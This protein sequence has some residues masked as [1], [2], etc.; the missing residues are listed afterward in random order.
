MS[1]TGTT[2]SFEIYE[3]GG[4]TEEIRL[5]IQIVIVA[6]RWRSLLDERLRTIG[7]SAARM[8][9][10]AAIMNSPDLSAQVE[11]AKR[12]RIEGPTM[13]RMLDT[14]EKDG[15]VER[16]P[17]PADRR[18]KQLRLTDAGR[19]ALADIFDIADALRHRLLH[20]LPPETIGLLNDALQD[21]SHRLDAGLPPPGS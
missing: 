4:T 11:I 5:T 9:A 20:G 13:T 12:L 10:M 18:S 15:L 14:L 2:S 21:L 16:L 17:D 6:R 19:A 7:Q 3:K 1:E 8:E